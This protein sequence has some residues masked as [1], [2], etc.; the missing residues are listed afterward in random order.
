M[1]DQWLEIKVEAP[2]VAVIVH[3]CTISQ[4]AS[5]FMACDRVEWLPNPHTY[6]VSGCIQLYGGSQVIPEI[7]WYSDRCTVT[8]VHG[9]GGVFEI[10]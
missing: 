7:I 6:A 9:R 8:G 4:P 5:T 1:L 2:R 10:T 3:S